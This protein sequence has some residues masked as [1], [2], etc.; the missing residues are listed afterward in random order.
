MLWDQRKLINLY[1]KKGANKLNRNDVNDFSP[2]F[3]G[4]SKLVG[5]FWGWL[6]LRCCCVASSSVVVVV[7]VAGCP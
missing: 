3:A 7:V 1:I 4:S 6:V 2:L 5:W